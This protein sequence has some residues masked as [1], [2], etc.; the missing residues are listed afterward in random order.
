MKFTTN[1]LA[2]AIVTSL[3]ACGGNYKDDKPENILETAAPKDKGLEL[4]AKSDCVTCHKGD[5]VLTGPSYDAIAKKYAGMP[6]TIV[7]HLAGKIISGGSGVWG[8][9][10]M[11]AHPTLSKEDAELM[12]RYILAFKK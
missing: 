10:P 11:V 7:A 1:I 6:D 9:V 3:I 5:E 12:T 4:I 8:Q 2:L